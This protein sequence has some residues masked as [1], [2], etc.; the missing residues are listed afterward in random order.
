MNARFTTM[1]RSVA[2]LGL[3]MVL[4][5]SAAGCGIF[6]PDT[7]SDGPGGGGGFPAMT[8][9][10][11]AVENFARAWE[12]RNYEEYEKIL[13]E[14]FVFYFAQEDIDNNAVPGESWPRVE[15]L[16]SADRIFNA[17]GT[18]RSVTSISIVLNPI[19]SW[20][21]QVAPEFAGTQKRTYFVN[22]NVNY[23]NGDIGDVRGQQVFYVAPTTQ[24]IEGNDVTVYKL[25][26]WR[27]LGFSEAP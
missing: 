15:E 26:F 4:V 1:L 8:T 17:G 19:D 3:G 7:A 18:S 16:Q 10:D 20:T 2:T 6:S 11:Q 25:K 14:G 22:M 27:D 23:S 21:D 5:L 12:E 24:N 9:P 13:D